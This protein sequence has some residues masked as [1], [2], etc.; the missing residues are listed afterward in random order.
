MPFPSLAFTDALIHPIHRYK[1]GARWVEYLSHIQWAFTALAINEFQGQT[2][3]RCETECAVLDAESGVCIEEVQR[4]G[5]DCAVTGEDVLKRLS[6][7]GQSVWEPI[8]SQVV[9]IAVLHILAFMSL[10]FMQPK[11]LG[12]K[13]PGPEEEKHNGKGDDESDKPIDN[14]LRVIPQAMGLARG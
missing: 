6:M 8:A 2:G 1:L 10:E 14:H 12:V 4:E 13:L 5:A 7:S 3:W 11:Y 9:L